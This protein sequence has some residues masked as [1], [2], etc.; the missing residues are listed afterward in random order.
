MPHKFDDNDRLPAVEELKGLREDHPS[1]VFYLDYLFDT[2]RKFF[3]AE[4]DS[5]VDIIKDERGVTLEGEAKIK[6]FLKV[7]RQWRDAATACERLD[8]SLGKVDAD[9]LKR[10]DDTLQ[11]EP[12]G[13]QVLLNL[14]CEA[15][16]LIGLGNAQEFIEAYFDRFPK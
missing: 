10:F 3:L 1:A 6:Y 5:P 16:T 15:G 4:I 12:F 2:Q 13:A 14:L 8:G 11:R 9:T 7:V